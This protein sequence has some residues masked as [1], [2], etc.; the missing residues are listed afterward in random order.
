M[1]SGT[2]AR[3]SP[4]RADSSPRRAPRSAMPPNAASSS[5]SR[6]GSARGKAS[7]AVP[8]SRPPSRA[9][10]A[11][12]RS[13]AESEIILLPRLKR[14]SA[15]NREAADDAAP[16][17]ASSPTPPVSP[18]PKR[19]ATA[20]RRKGNA[21]VST[22]DSDTS[23][24]VPMANGLNALHDLDA[25]LPQ[26]SQSAPAPASRLRGRAE[27]ATWDMPAAPAQRMEPLTWQQQAAPAA[28]APKTSRVHAQAEGRPT[29]SSPRKAAATS[30]APVSILQRG[31]T[32]PVMRDEPSLTW[33]QELMR[34][35]K[36][37]VNSSGPLPAWADPASK[38]PKPPA[39]AP[40]SSGKRRPHSAAVEP[41]AMDDVFAPGSASP[42]P[43][44]DKRPRHKSASGLSVAK[45]ALSN[46]HAAPPT[47]NG[48]ST[49]G[50]AGPR[51]HDSPSPASLPTPRI[52]TRRAAVAPQ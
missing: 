40:P 34:S 15:R 21:S 48:A 50:Y 47:S 49:F 30:V 41:F 33:Q 6:A 11:G 3:S 4:L 8:R 35:S 14:T 44:V 27:A 36:S 25:A 7:L 16:V 39:S 31:Q 52:L 42:A 24:P 22:H 45:P 13:G 20:R 32:E 37:T 18:R 43:A 1:P 19:T 12:S 9:S 38:P 10:T 29:R 28:A 51:I 2:V 26:I 23:V 17:P 5:P 46:D